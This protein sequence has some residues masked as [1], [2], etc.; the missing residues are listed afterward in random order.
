[1]NRPQKHPLPLVPRQQP[2][3]QSPPTANDLARHRDDRV[4][5]ALEL[6]GQ[7]P[8][9]LL[10]VKFPGAG[11]LGNLKRP[12]GLQVPRQARHHPVRPVAHQVVHRRTQ[13][14]HPALELRDQVLLVAAVVGLKHQ[15][16]GGGLP[17]VGQVESRADL[18]EQAR[19]A[20]LHRDRLADD[21][22]P[23]RPLT[24]RRLI[25][26]LGHIL[27]EPGQGLE[28]TRADD[29]VLDLLETLSRR[30]FG[31]GVWWSL[32]LGPGRCGQILGQRREIGHG[33]A[34]EEERHCLGVPGIELR[35]LGEVGLAAEGDL[36]EAGL[37]AEEDGQ[38]ELLGGVLVRRPVAGAIDDADHLAGVGQ[39]NDP[40]MRSPGAIV[41]DV[42]PLL[43]TGAGG[44]ACAV[45]VED[46]FVEEVGRLLLPDLQP[47]LIEDIPEGSRRRWW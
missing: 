15:T 32:Q 43:A 25:R 27:P 8:P 5:E 42:H 34:P 26:D 47:G 17:V 44:D 10:P 29:L 6:H 23:V 11:V 37:T 1:M 2:V 41:S 3:H 45:D 46:G 21:D 12:P 20:L 35:G 4:D 30:P 18:L 24:G 7:Q 14:A 28:L 39:G 40:G 19:L 38:V 31:R 9:L 16:A 13:R 36:E 22:Q 33:V